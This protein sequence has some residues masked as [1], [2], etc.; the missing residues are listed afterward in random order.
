VRGADGSGRYHLEVWTGEGQV[1][2]GKADCGRHQPGRL[3][4]RG[5]GR[6]VAE[7]SMKPAC[8]VGGASLRIGKKMKQ[9]QGEMTAAAVVT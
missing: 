5:Y 3:D 8:G 4:D 7:M 6:W 9:E 1:L 2:E